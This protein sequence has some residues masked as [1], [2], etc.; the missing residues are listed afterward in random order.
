MLRWDSTRFG[1]TLKRSRVFTL[2]IECPHTSPVQRRSRI[3]GHAQPRNR[4]R[5]RERQ[6]ERQRERDK[7]RQRE[8][9]REKWRERERE[10]ERGKERVRVCVRKREC[11][12]A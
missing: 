1:A 6:R 3:C 4:E 5:K 9:D 7:E 8:R 11:V 10:G 12:F 2:Q